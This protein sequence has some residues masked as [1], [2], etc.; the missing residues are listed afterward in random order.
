ME[1]MLEMALRALLV[2]LHVLAIPIW[3]VHF[4]TLGLIVSLILARQ[5]LR[6]RKLEALQT[7]RSQ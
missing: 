7:D 1:T 3:L 5:E 4:V 6:L 2:F